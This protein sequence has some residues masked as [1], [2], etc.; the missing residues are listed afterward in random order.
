MDLRALA[1]DPREA[2][3]AAWAAGHLRET[4]QLPERDALADELGR[5]LERGVLQQ[6]GRLSAR[7]QAIERRFSSCSTVNAASAVGPATRAS[8]QRR[9]QPA[10][11]TVSV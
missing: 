8:G 4:E 2:V 5:D 1:L 11:L 7:D 3:G 9:H 6:A 10:N